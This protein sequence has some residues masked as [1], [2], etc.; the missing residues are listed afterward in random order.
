MC[1]IYSTWYNTSI[2]FI[3]WF[4]ETISN[5]GF[6]CNINN[7]RRQSQAGRGC[8]ISFYNKAAIRRIFYYCIP[9]ITSL[10]NKYKR[11]RSYLL[12][13]Q[14]YDM[15]RSWIILSMSSF[16]RGERKKERK[17]SGCMIECLRLQVT[18]L[19]CVNS[20]WNMR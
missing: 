3:V 18:Q 2:Q 9:Y 1:N 13:K 6:V 8:N 11:A 7:K 10:W 17:T 20:K 4:K 14:L 19:I 12:Y 15:C 5:D 16:V